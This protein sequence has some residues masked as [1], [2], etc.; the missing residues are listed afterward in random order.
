MTRT[1]IAATRGRLV[2]VKPNHQ[3][4]ARRWLLSGI[5][6][7][8]VCQRPVRSARGI[9]HP[10][11]R[12]DGTRAPSKRYH[13][14][15]CIEGH[16]MRA[17]DILDEFVADLC[18]TRLS[19]DDLNS[20]LAPKTEEI[21][22]TALN[23]ERVALE[24]RKAFI[25]MNAV[26]EDVTPEEAQ[27]ALDTA[28]EKLRDLDSTIARAVQQ[29]PLAELIGVED[30]RGWWDSATLARQ[31]T[32]VDLLMTVAIKSVGAGKR[33]TTLDAAAETVEIAWKRG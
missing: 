15:R 4:T 30:V 7:C 10:N 29:D 18:I 24:G 2:G 28:N 20:L 19:E 25:L 9:T 12:K 31:R 23:A 6:I 13:T 27:V 5:A 26:N 11:P 17:G 33:I 22:V 8:A 21:D 14:Y 16:I 1:E 3:G 32:V